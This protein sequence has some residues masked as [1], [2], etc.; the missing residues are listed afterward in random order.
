MNEGWLEHANKVYKLFPLKK[1]YLI[2]LLI[3]IIFVSILDL[4]GISLLIPLVTSLL[5]NKNDFTTF[6]KITFISDFEI[7]N[8]NTIAIATLMI[9]I[10]SIKILL[11]LLSETIILFLSL[12][13]R[14][15]LRTNL[16]KIYVNKDYMDLI[17]SNSSELINSIQSYT[18]QHRGTV[19]NLLKLLNDIIFLF[20]TFLFVIYFYGSISLLVIFFMIIFILIFDKFTKNYLYKIGV[21]INK[22]NSKVIKLLSECFYGIKE[23]KIYKISHYYFNLLRDVSMQ[24][25]KIETIYEIL[26]RLPRIFFEYIVILIFLIFAIYSHMTNLELNNI[27]PDFT[28]IF[29]LILRLIPL[30]TSI[31]NN[32]KTIRHNMNGINNLFENFSLHLEKNL[33]SNTKIKL[34]NSK[35][36]SIEMKNIKFK[37]SDKNYIFENVNFKIKK[38]DFIGIIGNSGSGKT[39]LVDIILGVLK[40]TSGEILYNNSK[41]NIEDY[42]SGDFAAYI[43]QNNFIIDDTIEK[44]IALDHYKNDINYDILNSVLKKTNLIE[45][46]DSLPKKSKTIVGE[47]GKFLS[48]GQKQRIAIA[49]ALYFNKSLII[50]DESTNAMNKDLEKSIIDELVKLN[51]ELTIIII[52]HN[53][54]NLIH[55]NKIYN[56]ENKK[57]KEIKKL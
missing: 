42:Q 8:G 49:R 51:N 4:F 23:I 55:C 25:S 17:K 50:L 10:F 21:T 37:Y 34:I 36:Q 44:N 30:S 5:G 27:L 13:S 19:L 29:F 24:Q 31:S 16:L 57:L 47:H 33:I 2:Y 39:T 3:L 52:T 28:V 41:I 35:F 26:G 45:L 14:A 22:I 40:P 20:F 48:G 18:G 11:T 7:F 54:D 38:G 6:D 56:I 32:I 15:I 43:P 12:K 1:S 53:S 9:T 46:I